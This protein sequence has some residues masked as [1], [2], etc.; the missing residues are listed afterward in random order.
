[1]AMFSL[2]CDDSG[3]HAGSP[4]AV[5]ACLVAPVAQWERFVDDWQ[6]ANDKEN[7][8]VFH[9]ADF[10]SRHKQFASS[11]WQE[12]NKRDRTIKR[13]IS[14]ITTRS[15]I[16]FFNVV[17]K[18]AYDEEVPDNLKEKLTLGH[19][20][21]TFAVRMCLAK[22]L[23]WRMKYNHKEPIQFVFDRLSKGQG[24]ISSVM[25]HCL[26]DGID[27][28]FGIE[29][30]GWSFQ[31][32]SRILPLQAAD[33]LAWETLHHMRSVVLAGNGKTRGSYN[34]LLKMPTDHGW[35]HRKTLKELVSYWRVKHAVTP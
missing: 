21:Y 13:L 10:V 11:E 17:D 3:T 15:T 5:A 27:N 2:Y 34:A 29:P 22:V 1:M 18:V 19:N 6:R 7:F 33:I 24:E 25:Q 30:S 12:D 31:D 28:G 20:H 23:K 16:G 4:C 32:K 26:S 35:H 14:I 9:M 8:G